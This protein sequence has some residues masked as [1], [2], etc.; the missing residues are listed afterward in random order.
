MSTA[1]VKN[2]EDLS[3]EAVLARATTARGD[4]FPEWKPLAYASPK[5]YHLINQTVSY[6][7]SYHGQEA[8]SEQLSGPMR[9]LIAIPA[10]GAK[11]DLR[12]APN[13]V[14][15]AYRMGLTNKVLFEGAAAFAAVVGW[16]SMTFMSLAIIEA[17]NP[18]YPYGQLPAGGEP[19]EL[20]PFPEMALGR[21]RSGA[22]PE[23]LA[24][25][26]EWRYAAGIDPELVRRAAAF[27]DHCLVADGAQDAILGPGPRELIAIAALCTR[28]EV[29]LA[30]RH[31]RRA[32][33]YGMTRR[34]VLEAICC[35]LPMTG[36][37][38]GQ[39]GL[40]A[41]QMADAG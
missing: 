35:V 14:R 29:E 28:G 37:V 38:T 39:L 19:K 36:I 12:H 20:T 5:T 27:I 13:H 9:E 15:R 10:L 16:A 21:T 4:I 31:M 3:P 1:D 40:R 22:A 18:L 32:Y 2:A 25:T 23:S 24:D 8:T 26:P 17:N 30:A 6:L 34:H 41:M 7:H 11:G 33:D